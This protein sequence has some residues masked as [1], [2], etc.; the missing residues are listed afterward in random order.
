[1]ILMEKPKSCEFVGVGVWW[2]SGADDKE[3]FDFFF[4]VISVAQPHAGSTI[5]LTSRYVTIKT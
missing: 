1:M 5:I 4:S 2:G 3:G